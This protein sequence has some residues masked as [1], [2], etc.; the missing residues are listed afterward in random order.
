MGVTTAIWSSYDEV[1]LDDYP[2]LPYTN[3]FITTT[4][5]AGVSLLLV[6]FLRI[7]RQGHLKREASA[8]EHRNR[9]AKPTTPTLPR[10]PPTP[11]RHFHH[12][13]GHRPS[14]RW[15]P[16]DTVATSIVGERKHTA[17]ASVSSQSS[18]KSA[19]TPKTSSSAR[20]TIRRGRS[21][22]ERVVWIVCEECGTSKRHTQPRGPI[23][24]PARYFND[25]TF[26]GS[27]DGRNNHHHP[28]SSQTAS[29]NGNVQNHHHPHH[30]HPP[31]P[32][33]FGG[34]R[35]LPLVNRQ[36]MTHQML[37]QGFQP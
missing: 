21:P 18:R 35:R 27:V 33:P 32:R 24:D 12:E 22:S 14:K 3:T 8:S 2:E 20:T 26:S 31:L 11:P 34:R 1:R 30:H 4:A 17:A 36:I 23:G 9:N 10:L 29:N 13:H 15:S 5:F 28:T 37:T 16:V 7:G 19:D 25:P 6:P